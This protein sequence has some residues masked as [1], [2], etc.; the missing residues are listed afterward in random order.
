MKQQPHP[1][2]RVVSVRMPEEIIERLDALA[3]R[4]GRSRGLYLRLAVEWSL[5]AL[6]RFH[7]EQVAA[8]F[9]EAAIDRSFQQIMMYGLTHDTPEPQ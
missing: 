7:W 5:P 3:E 9:E 2:G 6:E 1:S 8:R 4:T